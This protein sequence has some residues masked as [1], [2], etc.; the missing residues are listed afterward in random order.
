MEKKTPPRRSDQTSLASSFAEPDLFRSLSYFVD[1]PLSTKFIQRGNGSRSHTVTCID[2]KAV[3]RDEV[4]MGLDSI[5]FYNDPSGSV[6]RHYIQRAHFYADKIVVHP[7][8]LDAA[9]TPPPKDSSLANLTRGLY[10]G[11][12][13]KSTGIRIR[14]RLEAWIKAV[15]YNKQAVPRGVRPDHSHIAFLTLTLPS[16]QCHSDNEIKRICL[17]PFIQQLKRLHGVKEYF[18]SAEPQRCGNIHFHL[19]IDRYIDKDR[20]CDLWNI[21][22]DHLGYLTRYVQKSGNIRPP[23]TRIQSCPK[24]MSLVKYVMKYVSKQPEI[25][26]SA[27]NIEGKKVKRISYWTVER[28]MGRIVA[29]YER[30]PIEGRCWGMSKGISVLS[31]YSQPCSERVLD[32]VSIMRWDPTIKFVQRD[33]CEVYYT[34]VHD[35]LMRQDRVLLADYRRYYV[36]LYRGLYYPLSQE[37]PATVPVIALDPDPP[38]TPRWYRQSQL[39]I[40]PY[41]CPRLTG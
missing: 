13:S 29:E 17:M 5:P 25:R 34:N 4:L 2:R 41:F 14:K 12:I 28:D 32:L 15:Q 18:W 26:C 1:H 31:V 8:R 19:L 27:K 23:S 7:Q 11:Y 30:R 22:V 39:D 21:A 20:A 16:K 36:Q 35:L 3:D 24:D 10:N 40:A 33:H 38:P 6:Q 9:P 37:Q